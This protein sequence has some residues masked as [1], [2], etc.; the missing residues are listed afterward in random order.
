MQAVADDEP[1]VVV[2]EG[3]QIDPPVLP[4]EHEREQVGLPQLVGLG[5]LEAADV[6]GM[7]LGRLLLQL[8]ARLVQHPGHGVRDWPASAG[9][10]TSMSLIRWQPQSGCA[11]LSIRIVR[12]VSSGSLLPCL[13]PLGWSI[14][15]A[16]PSSSN[17]FFQAYSVC[18]ETFTSAPKSRAG[19]PLRC[20]VSSSPNTVATVAGP[21]NGGTNGLFNQPYFAANQTNP[22]NYTY[23]NAYQFLD[24]ILTMKADGL[25]VP[26]TFRISSFPAST[27]FTPV[28]E[29]TSLTFVGAVLGT[30]A[31]THSRRRRS[32][33]S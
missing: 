21:F 27:S 7:R 30:V 19:R 25:T 3:H 17:R 11:C 2:H 15:P 33:S 22:F 29:P 5:P 28:P 9:P 8:I 16:G 6:I 14:S 32:G 23:N 10:R 1:A 31:A 18:C 12:L 26:G 20:Q 13:A 24:L 4:L